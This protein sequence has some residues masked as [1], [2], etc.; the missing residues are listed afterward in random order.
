MGQN[1]LELLITEARNKSYWNLWFFMF[2]TFTM[3]FTKNQKNRAL[4]LLIFEALKKTSLKLWKNVLLLCLS[5]TFKKKKNQIGLEWAWCALRS[6]NRILQFK[7]KIFEAR[8]KS[9]FKEFTIIFLE[10]K[11]MVLERTWST[12]STEACEFL[13]CISSVKIRLKPE[14]EF[15]VLENPFP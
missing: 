9:L 13:K 7:V 11:E 8:K 2:F 3:I 6:W 10:E 15:L 12:R 4:E 5:K 14:T 1:G